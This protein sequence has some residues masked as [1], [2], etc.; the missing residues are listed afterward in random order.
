MKP[1]LVEAEEMAML[2]AGL[3]H[4]LSA[5]I[6]SEYAALLNL[7]CENLSGLPN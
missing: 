7:V 1:G 2:M 6:Q 4:D 5:L 3:E